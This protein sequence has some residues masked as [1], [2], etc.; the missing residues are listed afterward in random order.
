V[1]MHAG[2]SLEQ[3]HVMEIAETIENLTKIGPCLR[4]STYSKVVD[5]YRLYLCLLMKLV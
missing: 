3:K 5:L 1:T 2:P 4:A